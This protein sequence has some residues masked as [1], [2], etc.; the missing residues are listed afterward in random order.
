LA[1]VKGRAPA[2]RYYLECVLMWI[3][4]RESNDFKTIINLQDEHGDTA[5]NI[6]ARVG[7]RSIVKTLVEVGANRLLPNKLGLRPG[8]FGVEEELLAPGASDVISSLQGPS[9]LPAQ[10]SKEVIADITSIVSSLSDDFEAEVKDKQMALEQA[11]RRLQLSTRQLAEQRRQIQKWQ[12]RCSELEQTQQRIRNLQRALAEED[13]FDWT[14]RSEWD[15]SP[16]TVE[17]AGPPFEHKGVASTLASLDADSEEGSGAMEADPTVPISD[18]PSSLIRLRRL[19]LWHRR[20]NKLL[21]DRLTAING[22][23]AEKELRCK[24]IISIATGFSVDQVEQMS[25]S[26]LMAMESE[27]H[28]GD[29]SRIAS[30]MQRVRSGEVGSNTLPWSFSH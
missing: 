1:G 11:Q 4:Q 23:S 8:D 12:A 6:A 16:S 9:G 10:K 25:G 18:S 19:A 17:T 20:A 27:P 7:N 28:L 24:K 2:A 15:G 29:L 13:S 30:F 3:A 22:A 14:G 21:G 5:L 26:L